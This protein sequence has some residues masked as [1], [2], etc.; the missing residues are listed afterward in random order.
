MKRRSPMEDL[1][2]ALSG[3][4][5]LITLNALYGETFD[6]EL[7]IWETR[8]QQKEIPEEHWCVY[9]QLF[10]EYMGYTEGEM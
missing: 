5:E 1:C 7:D 4:F 9:E 8:N 2:L 6:V 10:A 3:E